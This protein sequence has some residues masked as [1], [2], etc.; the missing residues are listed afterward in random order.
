LI[1]KLS[2]LGGVEMEEPISRISSIDTR[3]VWEMIKWRMN[4]RR[5][6]PETLASK[7][8]YSKSKIGRGLS[9]E[10]VEISLPFLHDCAIA[11][12]LVSARAELNTRNVR[13][14]TI[15]SYEYYIELIKPPSAM[16]P[17][18]GN[19]WEWDE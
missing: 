10:P 7:T 12:D 6:D 8:C 9:G 4:E 19:F 14:D 17:R 16:P 13:I 1:N 3:S 2:K 18:Q 11:F 15:L 5:V